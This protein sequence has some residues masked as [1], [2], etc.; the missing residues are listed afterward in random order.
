M[1]G[2]EP[3]DSPP[4][5]A[6]GTTPFEPCCWRPLGC[7]LPTLSNPESSR[8][9]AQAHACGP[10][11][12]AAAPR[13]TAAQPWTGPSCTRLFLSKPCA[14]PHGCAASGASLAHTQSCQLARAPP[15]L[16][17]PRAPAV[18][19][20]AWPPMAALLVRGLDSPASAPAQPTPSAR[21]HPFALPP[22]PTHTHTHAHTRVPRAAARASAPWAAYPCP[23][24]TLRGAS[25]RRIIGGKTTPRSAR[26]GPSWHP[27]I[28]GGARPL[29]RGRSDANPPSIAP[30]TPL[31]NVQRAGW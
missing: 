13:A 26:Q 18:R 6:G 15:P 29:V 8:L 10:L 22:P 31:S 19:S 21:S 27:C 30:S 23:H 2:V 9:A 25:G 16:E 3:L 7:R 24:P 5:P 14:P 20:S 12:R 1:A 17:E 4:S 11:P 28:H